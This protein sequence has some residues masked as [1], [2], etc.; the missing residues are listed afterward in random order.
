MDKN[1]LQKITKVQ[2]SNFIT[3][4]LLIDRFKRGEYSKSKVHTMPSYS[5]EDLIDNVLETPEGKECFEIFEDKMKLKY[6]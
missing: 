4:V 6:S 5:V 1:K 3:T 2:V